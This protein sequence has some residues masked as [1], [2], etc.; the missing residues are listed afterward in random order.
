[1][2]GDGVADVRR[3]RIAQRIREEAGAERMPPAVARETVRDQTFMLLLDEERALAAI[4]TMVPREEDRRRVIEN[5]ERILA[6]TGDSSPSR[7][8]RLA[9]VVKILGLRQAA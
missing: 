6:A 7:T 2:L 4:P 1:V 3:F 8:E 9:R 5:A